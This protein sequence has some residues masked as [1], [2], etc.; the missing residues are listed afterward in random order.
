MAPT[1]SKTKHKPEITKVWEEVL[2]L[3]I[4]YLHDIDDRNSVSLVSRKS[5]EIDGIARKRLTVHTLYYPNPASLNK[6]FPFIEALTLKGPP[7]NFN[8]T[9]DYDIQITPWI[10]QLALEF[11]MTNT[12][13]PPTVVNTTGAPVTN[14]VA[15]HAEKPEKFNDPLY[16]GVLQDTNC[17][18]GILKYWNAKYKTEDCSVQ[19]LQGFAARFHAEGMTFVKIF[20]L[21]LLLK[22]YSKLVEFKI[23]L[24]HKRKEM[25]VEDMVVRFVVLHCGWWIDTGATRHV[26]A[27]KSMFHSFRAVDNGQKLYMGNSATADI[28]GEGD[29]ILKMTSEK[30]LKLTNVLYVPEIRKNLVFRKDEAIDKFALYKTEVEN[31]LGKKIKVV[32]SDRGDDK[33]SKIRD[34]GDD[35]D[36]Q[37]RA[38]STDKKKSRTKKNKK[39]RNEE[40]RLDDFVSFMVE[41]EPNI[42]TE[43]RNFLEGQTIGEKPSKVPGMTKHMISVDYG[44][45]YD[46]HPAVIEGYS[47]ANWI[48]DIKD[49]R[50]TSGSDCLVRLYNRFWDVVSLVDLQLRA[51]ERQNGKIVLE[52]HDFGPKQFHN[53][54]SGFPDAS[55]YHISSQGTLHYTWKDGFPDYAFTTYRRKLQT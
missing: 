15:N 5:Y 17:T 24:K 3:V 16:N 34:K 8:V 35:N 11:R 12:Q 10:E 40:N 48:S 42:L 38:R 54:D 29:V 30:E 27:D 1:N 44:L 52:V 41:N 45:H 13:T 49:S 36:L 21:L 47:D 4:P 32:R 20:K 55:S 26:C 39:A 46:R 51:Q 14:A 50:S 25:S 43:K 7:S 33:L 31:Q 18:K 6:R 23:L 37:M 19:D 28:K 53:A 22:S 2:D 9:D